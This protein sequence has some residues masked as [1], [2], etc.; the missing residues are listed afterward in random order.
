MGFLSDF[1]SALSNAEDSSSTTDGGGS[2]PEVSN[3]EAAVNEVAANSHTVASVSVFG[4][5]SVEVKFYS[6]SRKS[7]WPA[8][9]DFDLASGNFTCH[10]TYRDSTEI[11]FFGEEVQSRIRGF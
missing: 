7:T 5:G 3:F 11:R 9:Y 10:A 1:L 2:R 4:Q 8:H 6:R